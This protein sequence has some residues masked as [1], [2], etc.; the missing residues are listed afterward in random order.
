ML[1]LTQFWPVGAVYAFLAPEIECLYFFV[2]SCPA[3]LPTPFFPLPPSS[4]LPSSLPSFS[5]IGVG[6]VHNMGQNQ[7]CI[8]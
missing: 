4:I 3:F 8:K 1:E 6:C 5:F 2:I 7:S